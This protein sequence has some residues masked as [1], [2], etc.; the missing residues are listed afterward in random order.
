MGNNKGCRG[1]KVIESQGAW[2]NPGKQKE[3]L[4]VKEKGNR[5]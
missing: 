5:R 4:G 3:L 1:Q 2:R